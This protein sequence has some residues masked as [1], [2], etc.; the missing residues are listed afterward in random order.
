MSQQFVLKVVNGQLYKADFAKKQWVAIP[1]GHTFHCNCGTYM[2]LNCPEAGLALVGH[3]ARE[4]GHVHTQHLKL[5]EGEYFTIGDK[6]FRMEYRSMHET[7]DL[8]ALIRQHGYDHL[9]TR[10]GSDAPLD[11]AE[12][13]PNVFDAEGRR[14]AGIDL[15]TNGQDS[16]RIILGA[17]FALAVRR[18]N[19]WNNRY[20]I[21]SIFLWPEAVFDQLEPYFNGKYFDISTPLWEYDNF[22]IKGTPRR[23][24]AVPVFETAIA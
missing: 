9:V 23:Q 2:V 18:P 10:L 20:R 5:I 12:H 13:Y 21:S 1:I 11:L 22:P 4:G 15:Y 14:Q 16:G 3:P 17:T 6:N 7:Y 24:S 19:R 8:A